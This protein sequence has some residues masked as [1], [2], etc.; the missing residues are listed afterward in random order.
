M[1]SSTSLVS[2]TVIVPA[3]TLDRWDLLCKAVASVQAQTRPPLELILC[4]DHNDALFERCVEQWGRPV[5]PL[6]LPIHV[7]ANRFE[8]DDTGTGVHVKAHGSR[9]RFG[10]GWARNTGAEKALGDVLVFLDDDAAADPDWLEFLLA[11]YEE[12]ATVAV[13]GAPLPAYETSRPPWF[14]SN[15]DWVFGCAYEGM[16]KQLGPLAHLI[17]ANM[18]VRRDAFEKI[19]GFHSI[20]FDDLDLCMRVAAHNPEQ[21]ILYEPKAIVHHFVPA[22][23]VTWH[24]FWRRCFF[25]NREKVE[26]FAGM[27]DAANLR[28]E[29]EFVRRAVTAQALN[30]LRDVARGRWIGLS[31]L[32]AMSVGLFMAGTG[33][34]WG[35]A[36]L[37]LRNPLQRQAATA[38]PQTDAA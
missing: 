17:G 26:A 1:P 37:F 5:S 9:R 18:S 32:G 6:G 4:I 14:P 28:A 12:P 7:V 30:A 3:Y 35:R 29:T 16:P 31:R 27:G 10:A 21:S 19:G 34:V 36:Q 20:D 11:P 8:Q 38:T 33:H 2:A 25:V 23:R 15:F 22:Q 13:G 24:Y